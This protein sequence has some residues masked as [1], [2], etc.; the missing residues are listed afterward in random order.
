MR[1][2]NENAETQKLQI[3]ISYK[4]ANHCYDKTKM[5]HALLFYA[6]DNNVIAQKLGMFNTKNILNFFLSKKYKQLSKI[7][8]VH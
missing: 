4:G 2:W 3:R 8:R 6:M 5:H 7:L 1:G